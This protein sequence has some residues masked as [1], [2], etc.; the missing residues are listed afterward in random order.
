M[1]RN[2]L[3]ELHRVH[4]AMDRRPD[5]Q[6]QFARPNNY[7]SHTRSAQYKYSTHTTSDDSWSGVLRNKPHTT[8]YIYDLRRLEY[9]S[10]TETREIFPF[11][12]YSI[13]AAV[14][15]P[16]P[17]DD[18]DHVEIICFGGL[19]QSG[20][21]SSFILRTHGDIKRIAFPYKPRSTPAQ[22]S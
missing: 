17:S 5:V 9:N 11:T 16:L 14:Q 13:K 19:K 20:Q 18:F 7:H 21:T 6:S 22:G 12:L 10:G 2:L 15:S 4:E 8:Y 3:A 1:Q